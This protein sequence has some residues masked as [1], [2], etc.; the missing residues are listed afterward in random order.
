MKVSTIWIICCLR[1]NSFPVEKRITQIIKQAIA[2]A[3]LSI[4]SGCHST[5]DWRR[6]SKESFPEVLSSSSVPSSSSSS[7]SSVSSSES[8]SISASAS[9]SWASKI[10]L[11]WTLCKRDTFQDLLRSFKSPKFEIAQVKP[12]N[13]PKAKAPYASS[14]SFVQCRRVSSA[15]SVEANKQLILP[16]WLVSLKDLSISAILL[17]HVSAS[18]LPFLSCIVCSAWGWFTCMHGQVSRKLSPRH[19][20]FAQ[21]LTFEDIWKY[22][23]VSPRSPTLARC[24]RGFASLSRQLEQV[25]WKASGF[26][27]ELKW[28]QLFIQSKSSFSTSPSKR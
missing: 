4:T 28:S 11:R 13:R 27:V 7:S 14:S 22:V 20:R 3:W 17:A 25:S 12:S 18:K 19:L 24:R 26:D 9:D 6:C 15:P 16:I 23:Q 5:R 21:G 2:P 8:S 1:V 10:T